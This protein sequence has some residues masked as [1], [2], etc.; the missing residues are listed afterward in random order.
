[1]SLAMP[2]VQLPVFMSFFWALQG[3]GEHF[4]GMESGGALW[5]TD[6]TVADS[7]LVRAYIDY[8]DYD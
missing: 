4:P 1:M 5:F 3:M 8:I 2:L 6:L 7:T